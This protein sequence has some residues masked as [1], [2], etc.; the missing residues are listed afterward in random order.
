M[1]LARYWGSDRFEA[2]VV[3][4]LIWLVALSGHVGWLIGA[5]WAE[6]Y[7]EDNLKWIKTII[8]L[9]RFSA[10]QPSAVATADE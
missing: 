4:P 5:D 7:T 2:Q 8:D 10:I 3:L 1:Q 9:R 6:V